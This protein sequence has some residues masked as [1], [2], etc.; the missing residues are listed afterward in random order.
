[1]S[2]LTHDERQ[3]RKLVKAQRS[4]V[5]KQRGK[6]AYAIVP[7]LDLYHHP[8]L[9]EKKVQVG[10]FLRTH[11]TRSVAPP[12]LIKYIANRWLNEQG[13]HYFPVPVIHMSNSQ[14]KDERNFRPPV[15][16]G[17][18]QAF[19]DNGWTCFA[20]R[21]L[22]PTGLM[23][24][25]KQMFPKA[26]DAAYIRS[27]GA[28]TIGDGIY[29]N[30]PVEIR[31]ITSTNEKGET[32]HA[33]C[34][35]AARC[36]PLLF[37]HAT[38]GRWINPYRGFFAKGLW[39]PD[40]RCT[41]EDGN[42][43]IWI[44]PL[45]VKGRQKEWA[46][47]VSGFA[48]G[49]FN[50]QGVLVDPDKLV[51]TRINHDPEQCKHPVLDQWYFGVL[52]QWD[53][54]GW[55]RWCFEVLER[56]RDTDENRDH[57]VDFLAE[58]LQELEERGG[59]MGILERLASEDP[60]IATTVALCTALSKKLN[61]D[62]SPLR[63]PFIWDYV[64]D[65]LQRK[66][67]HLRQGAG[68]RS[69]RYV[70]VMDNGVPRGHAV[71]GPVKGKDG[72]IRFKHGDE[73]A[74]TRFPMIAAQSLRVLK[75][76]TPSN[77]RSPHL[78]ESTTI[79]TE[80][81][82]RVPQYCIY[83]NPFDVEMM[84]G[85]DDG[86]TVLVDSDPRVVSMFKERISFRP[87]KPNLSYLIEPGKQADSWLSRVQLCEADG[88]PSKDA[89]KIV[90]LDRRGPVGALTY[91]LSG[92]ILLQ[93]R[94]GCEATIVLGQEAIDQGKHV[95]IGSD[96]DKLADASNWVEV[97]P[98]VLS[99]RNCKASEGSDWYDENGMLNMKK[100][101]KFFS[102]RSGGLKLADVL[103][104]RAEKGDKRTRDKEWSMKTSLGGENLVHWC[105]RAA[106]SLWNAWKE[107]NDESRPEPVHLINL[108]P[109]ALGIPV[110]E[111]QMTKREYHKLYNKSGLSKFQA[112]LRSVRKKQM[113]VEER[114][115]QVDA[116]NDTLSHSLSGL[117]RLELATIWW[118][119]L[120]KCP[121][122]DN[123]QNNMKGNVNRAFRAVCFEGSPILEELGVEHD[124]K[125]SFL[126]GEWL[127][128]M[129]DHLLEHVGS[130]YSDIFYA[131]ENW[132]NHALDHVDHTGVEAEECHDCKKLLRAKAVNFARNAKQ[133]PE[134]MNKIISALCTPVNEALKLL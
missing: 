126:K 46:K 32:I 103:T 85:D 99:P 105:D 40:D 2:E 77:R 54:P 91:Y 134:E 119:E 47:S 52:Q 88:N 89:V 115:R 84:Q 120:K 26:T 33:G 118:Q 57:I 28:P 101:A 82:Q 7:F 95:V 18:L 71:I 110:A 111:L 133:S 45:Q 11:V 129:F 81:G 10:K 96:P 36:H 98:N 80:F 86:D 128:D 106:Y 121:A 22:Y 14:D 17:V 49:A 68:K 116:G 66:L 92:F 90:G 42:P 20:G 130:D 131:V 117:T 27:L 21:H 3:A 24:V 48:T 6:A 108:I 51:I 124:T 100:F 132:A 76:I 104:W 114:N 12:S 62:I 30:L 125:C 63:V 41:D 56:I 113:D 87:G 79:K 16:E 25:F 122:G 31:D 5:S 44:D 102:D 8:V 1:M 15:G 107:D 39:V 97:A 50:E 34:D 43:T 72:N 75:C 35:G 58:A 61:R 70:C 64:Q 123:A 60:K 59:L 65:E 55:I 109:E 38:Q 19:A 93:D 73:I 37:E 13:E 127:D 94:G 53:K 67:Y 9:D 78:L 74:V 23:R 4:A 112:I 83:M 69:E 29:V